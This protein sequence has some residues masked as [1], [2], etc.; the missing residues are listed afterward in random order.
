AN[1]SDMNFA[2][3]ITNATSPLSLAKLGAGKL[4]L[5]GSNSYSGSTNIDG[6]TLA[7]ASAG[8]LPVGATVVNNASLLVGATITAGS[9]TGT[10]ITSIAAPATLTAASFS[11]N[12]LTMELAG[13]SASA[14]SKLQVTGNLSLGGSLT[15]GL[16]GSFT[17]SLGDAF[18]LLDWGTRSGAFSSLQ[19]PALAAPL[20]WST[21]QLYTAGMLSVIDGN[22][23]PGDLDR[24]GTVATADISELMAA[25]SD[26]DGYRA[27]HGPGGNP[28]TP[29][30]TL[31][32]GDPER[33]GQVTNAD[34]Q[35][36]IN[37]LANSAVDGGGSVT[38]VPEPQSI[39]LTALAT[40]IISRCHVRPA[41]LGFRRSN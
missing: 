39:I 31:E 20:V 24:D 5:S 4:T 37:N 16:T 14:N 26:L 12:G 28:L 34:L 15:V 3:T 38:A 18:D 13:A 27:T 30:Q 9:V 2:G 40:L 17:P 23:L 21:N 25:L 6:G 11:Q 8:A 35:V 10:G 41:Q 19:L 29:Q 1:S 36:L 7:L 32:E 33:D 22:F